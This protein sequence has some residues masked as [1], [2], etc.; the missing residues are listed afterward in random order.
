MNSNYHW[1]KHQTNG[2]LQA[3]LN[4]AEIHRSLKHHKKE[5]GHLSQ[6]LSTIVRLPAIGMSALMR[7]LMIHDRPGKTQTSH[8]A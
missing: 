5:A 7:R 6:L 8:N 2:R 4:E 1:Q 3:R